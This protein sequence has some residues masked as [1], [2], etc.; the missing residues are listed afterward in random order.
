[1]T[2][3]ELISR[4]LAA[5]KVIHESATRGTADYIIT[6]QNIGN[7]IRS[8]FTRTNRIMQI[9]KIFKKL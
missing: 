6:N 9:E 5:S 4:I 1:M 2:Q 7:I 8:G 3:S